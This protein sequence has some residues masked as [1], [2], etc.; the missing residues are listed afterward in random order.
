MSDLLTLLGAAVGGGGLTAVA[1][2]LLDRPNERA[3]RESREVATIRDVLAE[4]REER[5]GDAEEIRHLT[6]RVGLLEE[7]ERH[8]LTRAAVHEAWDQL[9]F[10]AL[11][12]QN[13]QHPPPPPL[14]IRQAAEDE[15]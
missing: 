13:P 11:L 3:R 6:E 7:R 8:M 5:A 14:T 12:I 9:A 4:L 1:V 10:Q 2:K 15:G